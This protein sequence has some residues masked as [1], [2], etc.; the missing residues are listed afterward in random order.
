MP[1]MNTIPFHSKPCR[2]FWKE[3]FYEFCKFFY[4]FQADSANS[5]HLAKP[6]YHRLTAHSTVQHAPRKEIAHHKQPQLSVTDTHPQQK[7]HHP[8]A[9]DKQHIRNRLRPMSAAPAHRRA[10]IIHDSPRNSCRKEYNGL[11]ELH[12]CGVFHQPNSLLQNPPMG[13]DSS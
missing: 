1:H 9:P 6:G 7:Q 11:Q 13:A 12:L 10:K 3:I 2:P 4:P 8:T 5:Q